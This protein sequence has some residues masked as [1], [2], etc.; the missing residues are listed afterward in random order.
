M[1]IT[2]II[3]EVKELGVKLV[4]ITGGE[5]MAQENTIHLM[6]SL[7]AEG[8]QVICE[9]GGSESLKNVPKDC[10]LIM[11]LKCP[12]SGMSD[13]NHWENLDYLKPNDEIKFVISSEKDFKWACEVIEQHNL[14][15]RFHCLMSV[16]FGLLEPATLVDWILEAGIDV[17]LNL[18][19]HKY[20][21]SPK[22][23]GV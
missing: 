17:R 5:P 15:G 20:I 2:E 8:F 9:T 16:A 12:D 1:T 11:D 10:T 3:A 22:A 13:R 21:W 6:E 4:E 23:K 18:Q 14:S 19:Q 7:S